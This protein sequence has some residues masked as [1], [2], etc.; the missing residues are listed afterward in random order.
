MNLEGRPPE[1]WGPESDK[2]RITEF[3]KEMFARWD[4]GRNQ[5]T[6]GKRMDPIKEAMEE[7]VDIGNYVMDAYFRLQNLDKKVNEYVEHKNCGTGGGGC[8]CIPR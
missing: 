4:A 8:H 3:G 2:K 1:E 6:D 7:C 5:Y